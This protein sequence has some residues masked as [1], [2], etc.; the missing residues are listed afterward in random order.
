MGEIT[1]E[2][3][4][5]RLGNVAQL[6]DLLFGEKTRHYDFQLEQYNQ[7]IDRLESN[8]EAFQ[9]IMDRRLNLMEDSLMQKINSAVDSLEKKIKYL[10]LTSQDETSKLKQ[11]IT[12]LE[13]L[14][15]DE[16]KEIRNSF[17]SQTK[18]LKTEIIQTKTILDRDIQ[19]VKQQLSDKIA[20]NLS[21]LT[22]GKVS[23]S[24]LAEVL[25]ELCLKVK[26]TD[27]IPDLTAAAN[28]G[29]QADFILPN[30][31]ANNES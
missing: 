7:K 3:M 10:S 14:K 20:K 19:A 11:E 4:R 28:N 26:G 17:N 1:Q 15:G 21:E 27:F 29:V 22:E 16:I 23:R 8:L 24:D 31:K 9:S 5:K 13:Q 18:N 12:S 30:E 25:F 6:Q 2:E